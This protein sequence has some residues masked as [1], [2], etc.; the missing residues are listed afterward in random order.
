M[1]L[2][3]FLAK[4]LY[5][6][7]NGK[8]TAS[9]PA[10]LIAKLGIAIGLA[11][12]LITLSV[13]VGFKKEVRD[14]VVG[15]GVHLRV[16]NAE[17]GDNF[18]SLPVAV[19]DSMMNG[20]SGIE[21]VKHLQ[22]YIFKPGMIKTDND[23]QGVVLKGVGEEY[24]AS[25]F[26]NHLVEGVFPRFTSE[27]ASNEVVISKVLADKLHLKLGEKIF[28]YFIQG[29]MKVRRMKVA[30]IYE[31][32]FNEYDDMFI[33]TDLYALRRLN[34][35]DKDCVTGVEMELNR[36][37]DLQTVTDRV[38]ETIMGKKDRLGSLFTVLNIEQLNPQIFAWLGL[39]DMNFW[40]IIILMIGVAGFTII[41]GLL[42][43]IIERTSTIGVLKSMGTDN[44]T[45]RKTFLWLAVFLIGRGML[46]GNAVGMA[47]FCVQKYWAPLTLDPG[48]Y[49]MDRVPVSMEWWM[50]LLLNAGTLLIAVLMLIGPSYLITRIHPA[51]AMRYE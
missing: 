32:H 42:I 48:T 9:R 19:S 37:G 28:I 34:R 1:N 33:L 21:G 4:R 7:N 49:Y 8:E 18:E 43:I 5:K 20:L 12:L 23:F 17:A 45:V 22:R 6:T 35:W 14:K 29:G 44:R 47:F 24:D 27:K 30:G 11:V 38:G 15:F 25:F 2:P 3:L 31:T 51:N 36:Y 41:S 50:F 16:C 26:K 10:V 13:V 46:W 39:L 40:V